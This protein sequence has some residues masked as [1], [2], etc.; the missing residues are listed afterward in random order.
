VRRTLLCFIAGVAACG[1]AESA[2]GPTMAVTQSE[3]LGS[4]PMR[5]VSREDVA[6]HVADRHQV[7]WTKAATLMLHGTQACIDGRDA[8]AIVGT[9][10]GDAG[11]LVLSLAAA[12]RLAGRA[13]TQSEVAEI[14]D[15]YLEA[16]GHFYM[17]SDDVAAAALL[18]RIQADHPDAALPSADDHE[19]VTQL[20]RSPPPELR[21]TMLEALAEPELVGC[22]HLR[23]MLQEPEAYG[24]RPE[25]V[26]EVMQEFY[27]SLWDG[28][29]APEL[30]VLHGRHEESAVVTIELENEVH[31][32]TRIPLVSPRVG[33]T[34]IFVLHP[35]VAQ[36]VRRENA[37]FLRE[38]VPLLHDDVDEDAFFHALEQLAA[39]QRSATLARLAPTLPRY[40]VVFRGDAF[41]VFGPTAPGE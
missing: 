14:F 27:R 2:K 38:Q 9:P 17:H 28:H 30:V 19:A 37:A 41:E 34:E 7:R 3:A 33:D 8:H 10:G 26:A 36:F 12:E 4:A 29:P 23:L 13:F 18:E 1:V 21:D 22:G 16:F 6:D 11:E 32:Y 5:A 15:A 39:R 35:Q 25:L 20:M 40:H 24:V 31:T